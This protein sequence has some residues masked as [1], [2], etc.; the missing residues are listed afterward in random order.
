M[1][2][3]RCLRVSRLT[4]LLVWLATQAAAQGGDAAVAP[5]DDEA[6]SGAGARALEAKLQ[7]IARLIDTETAVIEASGNRDAIEQLQAALRLRQAAVDAHSRNDDAAGDGRASEALR[8]LG[9]ALRA[10]RSRQ[11]DAAAWRS[12]YHEV[13]ARVAGFRQAYARI[14]AEKARSRGGVL[15]EP[16]LDDLISRAEKLMHEG[17]HKESVTTLTR[18]A[19]MVES[20]L[21]QIRDKETLI[22]ELKF[23]SPEEEYA[24]D[25]SRN[26]SYEML[27][28]IAIT[29]G[30]LASVSQEAGTAAM[31]ENRAA[32]ERA[33]A[34]L[35]AGDAKAGIRMLETATAALMQVLREGGLPLP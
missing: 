1:M 33:Q 7:L 18:A 24:Y 35:R 31:R 22:H 2:H 6:K 30:K 8:A 23:N 29:E 10:V 9:Q 16:A 21:M 32:R 19:V 13:R 27:V 11:N 14:N 3:W 20:A 34:A 4:L 5:A 12:R 26:Q 25:R 28:E 15:D 17:S